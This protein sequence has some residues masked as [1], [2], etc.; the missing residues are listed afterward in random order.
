LSHKTSTLRRACILPFI[1]Q[2]LPGTLVRAA[3]AD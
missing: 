1:A 3:Y 2:E